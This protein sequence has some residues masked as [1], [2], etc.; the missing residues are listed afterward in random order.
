MNVNTTEALP[1]TN[2]GHM[3]INDF[4]TKYKLHLA[5]DK[6]DDTLVIPGKIG[7]NIRVW[8]CRA[9]TDDSSA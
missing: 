1:M 9:W 2:R 6:Q 4:A 7:P 8:P 3:T 5:K